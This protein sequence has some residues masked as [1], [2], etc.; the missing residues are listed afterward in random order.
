MPKATINAIT[1]NAI[2]DRLL[3]MSLT[4]MK[5]VAGLF[6]FDSV[7]ETDF[8]HAALESNRSAKN[9]RVAKGKVVGTFAFQRMRVTYVL[10]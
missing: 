10:S 5:N 7:C 2:V 3:N 9:W 1:G 4:S 8:H 6:R